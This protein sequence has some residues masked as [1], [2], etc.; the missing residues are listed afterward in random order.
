MLI[1]WLYYELKPYLPLALRVLLRRC[2][3]RQMWRRHGATWPVDE[4]A[5][6]LPEG[7][8]GW[9]EDRQFAL[10]LT[11]DVEG[12]LGLR[13]CAELMALEET[14]GF[15]SAFNFIPEGP[16]TVSPELRRTLAEHGFEVGV[17]DLHHDGKLFRSR[18]GFLRR[19]A[20]INHYLKAWETQG[21]RAGLMLRNLDYFHHLDIR[22]DCTTFDTDPFEPQPGGVRTIFPFY[23]K[24]RA[25]RDGYAELPN[26]LVQDSTLFINLQRED[27]DLWQRKLAWVAEHGGMALVNVHP[28]YMAFG[29]GLPALNQYPA[30]CYVN[31]LRHIRATYAGRYWLALPRQVADFVHAH[32]AALGR[33]VVRDRPYRRVA[34]LTHSEYESDNRVMRYSEAL[35]QR[36][37]EVEVLALRSSAHQPDEEPSHGVRV[38][39]LRKRFAKRG[40]SRLLYIWSSLLFMGQAALTLWRRH[41]RDPYDLIHVHNLPDFLVLAALYPRLRGS[42]VILDIHDLLPEF[43][44]AKFKSHRWGGLVGL[45]EGIERFSARC[46][47]QLIISNHLWYSKYARR[48]APRG[49][50]TVVLNHVD[51]SIFHPRARSS[52]T[53]KKVILFPGGLYWH[54]GL[55]LVIRAFP[56]VLAAFP[57]A[58]FHLYG[59]GDQKESLV[60][61]T[62]TLGLE[63]RVRFLGLRPLRQIAQIMAQADLGVVPKRADSFGNEAY[64][65]KIM[66][67]MAVGTPVAISRTRIDEYY[68][69]EA[70]VRFFESGNLEQ[71]AAAICELLANPELR[72][73]QV[74]N[75]LAYVRENSWEVRKSEY[76]ALV[77]GLIART[78]PAPAGPPGAKP[79]T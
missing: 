61:L 36:G 58:E 48:A 44:A 72:E 28:D 63:G 19:A 73:R 1:T 9:P 50:C 7:W 4:A 42:R 22:Y 76:L 46:A 8:P 32:K 77:D 38:T 71:I 37:D 6:R 24:G 53:G 40:P 11:H 75:A 55:D 65:T 10:V 21:F 35:A 62:R 26:T 2:H 33:T 69:T 14:L 52:A 5:G 79:A 68:F 31:F 29:R 49:N 16:Y 54:Q 25:G 74:R 78:A 59:D 23:V 18:A 20:R 15:R 51:A 39:H 43:Y 47:D 27:P 13:H 12:P 3:A 64:S 57:E 45:L 34:M 70:V 66:E 41:R 56:K 30:Q 67:F 60:S 17:H